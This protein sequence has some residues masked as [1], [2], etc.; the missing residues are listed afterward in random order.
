LRERVRD[1]AVVVDGTR[2]LGHHQLVAVTQ[3]HCGAR[4]PHAPERDYRGETHGSRRV[5]GE[6]DHGFGSTDPCER[7]GAGMPQIHVLVIVCREHLDDRCNRRPVRDAAER[8]GREKARPR[9]RIAQ[10]R[11][12]LAGRGGVPEVADQLR[13]LRPDFRIA[14]PQES[15]E[16][17]SEPRIPARELADAPQPVD[18]CELMRRLPR[19]CD[20]LVGRPAIDELEL[21]FR[22]HAHVSMLEQRQQVGRRSF[23]EVRGEQRARLGT[24]RCGRA[25]RDIELPDPPAL[26]RVPPL[27]PVRDVERAVRAEFDTR[28]EQPLHDDFVLGQAK[29]RA[30]R[31]EPEPLNAG[32]ALRPG[33][34][35]AEKVATPGCIECTAGVVVESG[36]PRMPRSDRRRDVRRLPGE[37]RLEQTLI[38]PD[39]VRVVVG[40]DVLAEL[41]VDAPA[42]VHPVDDVEESLVL[43]LV[44]AVVVR[45]DQVAVLVERE[46]L[47]VAQS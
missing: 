10:Q 26:L 18:A 9:R 25:T 32:A 35:G 6:R 39:V 13:C 11:D 29:S 23:S 12:Q 15:D 28:R 47:R 43:S 27:D 42:A 5:L 44:I 36:R 46:L 16:C 24:Q 40:I 31:G 14:I 41:P 45:S 21:C 20:Q 22:A 4:V 1:T 34:H 37:A 19:G 30:V 3:E 2:R 7:E 38:H 17:T 8:F 33:E